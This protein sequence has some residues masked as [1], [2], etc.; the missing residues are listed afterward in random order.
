M[1]LRVELF[2]ADLDVFVDFYTRVLGFEVFADRRREDPSY[3]AVR[4]G[5]V[6]IGAARAWAPVDRSARGL[7]TGTELV[8]ETDDDLTAE[9]NRIVAAWPL[10]EDLTERP[11]GLTDFR[12]YDPDGYYLRVTTRE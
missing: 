12:L 4:R 3:A 7:P 8:L 10:E 2:V 11:W 9:R 5:R 1:E 6:Q